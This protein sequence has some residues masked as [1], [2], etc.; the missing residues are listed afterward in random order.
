MRAS[1]RTRPWRMV[2]IVLLLLA[3]GFVTAEKLALRAKLTGGPHK[4]R[5]VV[6]AEKIPGFEAQSLKVGDLVYKKG[7]LTQ[8]FGK[9]VDVQVKPARVASVDRQTGETRI[10]EAPTYY[11]AFI[12]IEASAN[13][14]PL[15][16]TLVNNSLLQLNQYLPLFTSHS[17][18]E[19]RVISID[20][21]TQEG[22]S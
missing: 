18:V 6:S 7:E 2:L 3:L 13:L 11:D 8:L 15:G 16:N 1:T 19:T 22:K 17:S 10:V 20:H 14:S 21:R 9:I 4:T 12:T 5:I